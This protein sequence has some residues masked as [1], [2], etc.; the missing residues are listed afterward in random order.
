MPEAFF[1]INKADTLPDCFEKKKIILRNKGSQE[2]REVDLLV[3]FQ[4]ESGVSAVLQK[5]G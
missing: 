2:I 1:I 3:T 4:E 5:L